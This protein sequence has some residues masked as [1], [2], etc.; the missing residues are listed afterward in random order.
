MEI[1]RGE[2]YTVDLI[3]KDAKGMEISKKRPAV[4]VQADEWN[5]RLP[6]TIVVPTTSYRPTYVSAG[7][8]VLGEGEIN[9]EKDSTL[10]FS[11]MRSIDKGRLEKRVGKV[12][13]GKMK[14]ID[15]ALSLTLGL[16][17]LD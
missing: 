1:K 13:A 3:E 8:V 4:V 2:V 6:S 11:Q 12:S 7:T 5:K 17:P 14:E 10:L 9:L 16:T 15:K